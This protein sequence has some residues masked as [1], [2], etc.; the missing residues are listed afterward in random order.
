MDKTEKFL[1]A[2]GLIP[3]PLFLLGTGLSGWLATDYSGVSQHASELLAKGGASELLLRITAIGTGSAFMLFSFG[4]WKK[5]NYGMA[6]GAL[7]W[8]V[9]GLSMVTNGV[10]PMGSA[11]HGLYGLG[12]FN[13]IAP[14]VA[15]MDLKEFFTRRSHYYMTVLVSVCGIIYLWLNMTGNDPGQ[16]RGATQRLFSSINSLWP[17]FV[18]YYFLFQKKNECADTAR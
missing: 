10:W 11:M 7:A 3:L 4:L 12:M 17:F 2:C 1:L 14:A 15:H 5:L 13:L 6:V 8:S 9:F 16:Y 18:A